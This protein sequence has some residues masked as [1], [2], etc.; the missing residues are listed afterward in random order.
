[1]APKTKKK[2]ILKIVKRKTI[3]KQKININKGF[4]DLLKKFST[5]VKVIYSFINLIIGNMIKFLKYLC[6]LLLNLI[7]KI[8]KFLSG[9]KEA[10]FSILF[11]LLAGGIGAVII[12][13]YFDLNTQG[14]TTEYESKILDGEKIIFQL[15]SEINK[16]NIRFEKFQSTLNELKS[17]LDAAE[18][19]NLNNE[20][21]I[22]E[23]NNKIEELFNITNANNQKIETSDKVSKNKISELEK[24]IENT[25]KLMLSSSKSE[26]SNR[27]YLA[28]S[29]VDRLK[30]GVPYSPQL[31]A[32]GQEGLDPALLRF[33]KGGA[34]TLSDL[35]A[36]LSAR[37]GEL[38]DSLK[39]KSDLTWKDSLK[40]EISKLVKIKPTNSE[41]IEGMEGVLLRA[42]EA[43]TKGDLEKAIA[44][45]NSLEVSARGVLDVWLKEAK[46]KKDAKVAAENI[47]AKTTAALN[48]KN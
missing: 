20:N 12:F 7:K 11:G 29:L 19:N 24:I 18:K 10:F 38:R 25:S 40:D 8:V 48:I 2:K 46:A 43:I 41:D 13:S 5:V 27:L 26:L 39:T 23:Y 15:K 34:P 33:A 37:A 17:R 47:L 22:S 31:V 28:K 6:A 3:N 44:E 1:M 14:I 36:R 30:A 35:A 4:T 42:E 45:I 32:L 9:V 16:S 21:I